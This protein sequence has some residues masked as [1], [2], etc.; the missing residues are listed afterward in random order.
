MLPAS[1]LDFEAPKTSAI[2]NKT[3]RSP[4]ASPLERVKLMKLAW[5]AVGSEFGSRHLQY[6]MF[7]SGASFVTRGNSFRFFDW[8]TATGFVDEFMASYDLPAAQN[9]TPAAE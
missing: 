4:I 2:I 1:H 5:D 8:D 9:L 6:E 3:Q 7:Y